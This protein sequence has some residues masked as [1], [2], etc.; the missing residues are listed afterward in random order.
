MRPT[1][2]AAPGRGP[3]RPEGA[4]S[5]RPEDAR[6]IGAVV[7]N[8][9][10]RA[11]STGLAGLLGFW[12][13][14][15]WF[16]PTSVGLLVEGAVLGGL[17]ALMALGLAL[18]YRSNRIINFAAADLGSPAAVLGVMLITALHWSYWVAIPVALLAALLVGAAVEFLV[19]RPFFKAPR[20]I[21]TVVTIGLAQVLGAL[22]ILI[23]QGFD[24]DI[25]AQDY[26]SPFDWAF[27]VGNHRFTGNHVIAML[28]I[29]AVIAALVFFFRRTSLGIAVRASASSADRAALLGVPV[30][31]MQ[32]TVWMLAS[33]FA[34]LSM[35]LRA[36][37]IGLPIGRLLGP[38]ILLPALAAAV[39]GR[40]ER[41]G[42]IV[43]ASLAVGMID[44][45][46]FSSTTRA[47]NVAPILFLVILVALLVQRRGAGRVDPGAASTWR[48][49]QEVRRIP[50]ELRRLPEVRLAKIGLGVV[51]LGF[52]VAAPAL[53]SHGDLIRLGGIGVFAIVG[54]SLVVLTG[55][56][57]EVSLGQ[58]AFLGVGSAVAGGLTQ[59]HDLDLA[60]AL[61]LAGFAGALV[62]VLIGLPALR[63][64]GMFLAVT[65]L[66]FALAASD[67]LLSLSHFGRYLP[68]GLVERP[69]LLGRISVVSEERFYYLIVASL[70]L[71][72]AAARGIRNSRSGR[73][74][75][76]LRENERA[77]EAFGVNATRVKLTAFAVSGFLAAWAGALFVHL[78]RSLGVSPYLPEE[79]L[80]A[81]TMVV[82]G[83]L[84]S[85]PGAVIGAVYVR[86]L[87]WFLPRWLPGELAAVAPLLASGLGLILVLLL[88][89]GGLAAALFDLRDNL[90]RRVAERRGILVPSLLADARPEPAGQD[91]SAPEPPPRRRAR[92]GAGAR[93][94][95]QSE[96]RAR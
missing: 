53:V 45:A 44:V 4:G 47:S 17:T 82:I 52:A 18:I 73:V 14:L 8:P 71:A 25:P 29:P 74:L 23:P 20:L 24:Q 70:L 50:R 81:F 55:W 12:F 13:V 63:V 86:G 58:V 95:P 79:S 42:T 7:D 34:T 87:D 89:R 91:L 5:G 37:I 51:L 19:I 56:G 57:G 31:R 96:G 94:A 40:F 85:I 84:G 39:I 49:V 43:V 38:S 61:V 67:Y 66:A 2:D 64:R 11:L 90:L 33:L 80:K 59:R 46:V 1:E 93:A 69:P 21:L 35:L 68:A 27:T 75:I 77:A 65:T 6:R 10:V 15:Q 83:G 78:N 60:L 16:W 28:A 88:V 76:A 92:A 22:S 36:G 9:R 62:A 54:I 48:A 3:E 41:F 72:I 30:K 26:P 32:T